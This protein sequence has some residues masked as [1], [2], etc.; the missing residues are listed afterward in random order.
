MKQ[1]FYTSVFLLLISCGNN[2]TADNSLALTNNKT[3]VE[4]PIEAK[5]KTPN[6][7][8]ADTLI[9]TVNKTHFLITPE[10]KM[11]WGENPADTI[12]LLTDVTIEKAFLH[13]NGDTLL[14][15]YTETDN[16]GATSRFEKIN[17]ASRQRILKAEIQG[18]NLGLPYIIGNFAYVTT[19]GTVGKLNLD[20]G[21]YAYQYIDLYDHKKYSFNSFDT[22]I[23]KD[24][25][26]FFLSENRNSKRI[27]S[28]IVNEKTGD[29][30]I[31]K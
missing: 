25:L 7:P 14:I 13:L 5:I 21:Q 16:D 17:L 31:K 10:G 24:N 29:R 4:F 28:L 12:R 8:V 23:F 18:F 30:T 27:D 20:N 26:T 1:L 6:L 9:A 11:F 19:L 15:F 2:Q 22:I 3:N